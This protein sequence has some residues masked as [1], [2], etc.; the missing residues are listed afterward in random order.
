M[1]DKDE[2]EMMSIHSVFSR[3]LKDPEKFLPNVQKEGGGVKGVLHNVKKLHNLNWDIP[4][5]SLCSW[6]QVFVDTSKHFPEVTF[7]SPQ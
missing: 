2:P 3:K 6:L 7:C 5:H 1:Q 4:N